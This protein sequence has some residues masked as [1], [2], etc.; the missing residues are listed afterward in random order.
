MTL[1]EYITREIEAA[2]TTPYFPDNDSQREG[3]IHAMEEVL[4]LLKDQS[5]LEDKL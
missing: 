3:Y 2:R 4:N 5:L 1:A